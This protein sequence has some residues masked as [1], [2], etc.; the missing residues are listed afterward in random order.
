MFR[1][2]SPRRRRDSRREELNSFADVPAL[3]QRH[4]VVGDFVIA[5]PIVDLCTLRFALSVSRPTSLR[6]QSALTKHHQNRPFGGA[7]RN[8]ESRE[9]LGARVSLVLD[10]ELLDV[11]MPA[12]ARDVPRRFGAPVERAHH[13]RTVRQKRIANADVSAAQ[14]RA[15]LSTHTHTQKRKSAKMARKNRTATQRREAGWHH[16]RAGY[17][18]R[19]L[20][21]ADRS[22]PVRGRIVPQRTKA[23]RRSDALHSQ[24][25][26]QEKK[27]KHYS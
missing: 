18:G 24:H 12:P 8:R 13:H 19:R 11:D 26:R 25:S 20:R 22:P 6:R 1:F 5:Q 10:N 2:S 27:R 4:H 7:Q 3:R 15:P 16:E 14:R 17:S 9:Q 21:R 23:W